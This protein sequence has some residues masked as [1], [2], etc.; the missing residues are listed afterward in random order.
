MSEKYLA[1]ENFPA[2]TVRFLREKGDDVVYAAEIMIGASDEVILQTAVEQDR[3]VLTFDRDF[4]ELAF[5]QRRPSAPGV[6]L[7]R[8]GQISP[9]Q[10]LSFLRIFFES[11]PKLR[12]FFTVASP[13]HFRQV[14][15][16]TA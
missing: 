15:L 10:M 2:E 13:G 16:A 14:R 9:D 7:F 6:V 11:Q 12:G 3:V 8:L 4:G 1:N 5:H